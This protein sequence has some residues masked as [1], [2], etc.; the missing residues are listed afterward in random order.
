MSTL[1]AVS[2]TTNRWRK[3][4]VVGNTTFWNLH[5]I[6]FSRKHASQMWKKFCAVVYRM[7]EYLL[8]MTRM[9]VFNF[10]Q[11]TSLSQTYNST[12]PHGPSLLFYS[13]EETV[14]REDLQSGL[15]ILLLVP[16]SVSHQT[17]CLFSVQRPSEPCLRS[18]DSLCI[19]VCVCIYII[20]LPS[21]DQ[22]TLGVSIT[23]LL[24]DS[25]DVFSAVRNIRKML[26]CLMADLAL[27]AT[28][29]KV[30]TLPRCWAWW[31]F[32]PP[33]WWVVSSQDESPA[34]NWAYRIL[35][36]I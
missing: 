11:V 29:P 10:L 5:K 8:G 4:A 28:T 36:F 6:F 31:N 16:T 24:S 14:S 33:P 26:W 3:R 1:P 22:P 23:Q 30:D 12:K 18:K 7:Y 21:Q 34:W 20:F 9:F 15:W 25:L 2:S 13:W 19:C 32:F 27:Y 17:I 35:L